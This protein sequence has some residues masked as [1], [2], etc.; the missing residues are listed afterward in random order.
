MRAYTKILAGVLIVLIILAAIAGG[1]LD[2]HDV[3]QGLWP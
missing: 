3:P 2:T 1:F